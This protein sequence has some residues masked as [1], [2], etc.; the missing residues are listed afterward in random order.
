MIGAS[1]ATQ[2]KDAAVI[3]DDEC[4]RGDQEETSHEAPLELTW[5][6]IADLKPVQR[7]APPQGRF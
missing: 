7:G 4:R 3:A 2:E 5:M 6:P 1:A